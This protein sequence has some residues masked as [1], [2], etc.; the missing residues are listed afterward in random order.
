[1][2]QDLV[3][4][5][6]WA[7][8][9]LLDAMRAH[10][11][12]AS[13]PE[14][15]GLLHHIILADRFWFALSR[16]QPF[17]AVG[18]SRVPSSLAGVID[19]FAETHGAQLVWIAALEEGVLARELESPYFPGRR[20]TIAQA[21]MQ[22]CLHSHGHRAQAATRLRS[23]GG[24]PPPMDFVMWLRDRPAGAV[25]DAAMRPLTHEDS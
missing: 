4:H 15:R 14:L 21:M 8:T 9:S 7:N 12:A 19:Q 10:D 17:D 11:P 2:I 1:M 24:T 25:S 13:D 22:V 20:V 5:K 3:R 18:E 23:L 6:V 16:A